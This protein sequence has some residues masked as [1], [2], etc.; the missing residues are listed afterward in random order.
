LAAGLLSIS[1][2]GA[3]EYEGSWASERTF[4]GEKF[5]YEV[6]LVRR[7]S[8]IVGIWS[9]EGFRSSV[10]CIRGQSSLRPLPAK[11]CSLDGSVS[12]KDLNSVCPSY[13]KGTNRFV[14]KGSSLVWETKQVASSRWRVFVSLKKIRETRNIEWPDE[15][16]A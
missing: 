4:G 10:G 6:S 16:G 11:M 14:L 9:V 3:T 15:C 8:E 2:I 13:E 7:G 5:L 1:S 12:S